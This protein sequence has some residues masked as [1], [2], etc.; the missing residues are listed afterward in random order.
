[1]ISLNVLPPRH[2]V[3]LITTS[4]RPSPVGKF[5]LLFVSCC[6]VNWLSTLSVKAP[7]PLPSTPVRSKF[8][9]LRK[10]LSY[11]GPF[12]GHNSIT[13]K[14]ILLFFINSKSKCII[15]L[16]LMK[17]QTKIIH[18]FRQFVLVKCR[19]FFS[20]YFYFNLYKVRVQI[21]NVFNCQFFNFFLYVLSKQAIIIII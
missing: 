20:I 21:L 7:K 10:P 8:C 6:P 19:S 3:W 2:L 12:Q 9:L 14:R 15:I 1:M 17:Y 18:T 4:V 5:K 13:L 16:L 11:K